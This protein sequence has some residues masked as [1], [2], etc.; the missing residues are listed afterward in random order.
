[1]CPRDTS[2]EAWKVYL[3]V[4]R[5]M[6]PGERLRKALEL[7]DEVSRAIAAGLRLLYPDADDR[8]IFLRQARL[9]LGPE[10]FSKAYGVTMD[11]DDRADNLVATTIEAVEVA[12]FRRMVSGGS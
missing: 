4:L 1:M 8:E 5:R 6:S 9:K 12:N 11:S 7:S 3:E 2:Q 10:L